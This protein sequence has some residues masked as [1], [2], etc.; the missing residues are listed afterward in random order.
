[1][2]DCFK[3]QKGQEV[4]NIKQAFTKLTE[5]IK[6]AEKAA[7]TKLENEIKLRKQYLAKEVSIQELENKKNEW[8]KEVE[9]LGNITQGAYQFRNISD[10]LRYLDEKESESFLLKRGEYLFLQYSSSENVIK[11]KIDTETAKLTT[12][13]SEDIDKAID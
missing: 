9:T 7:L 2:D 11:S 3:E 10:A 13:L 8:Y 6:K 4:K 1:M 5:K 12:V